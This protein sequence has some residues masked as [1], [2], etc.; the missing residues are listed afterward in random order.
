MRAHAPVVISGMVQ[1]KEG[2]DRL[3]ER[4]ARS[5]TGER[6]RQGYSAHINV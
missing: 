3:E 6:L 2:D 5:E 1:Q 4:N